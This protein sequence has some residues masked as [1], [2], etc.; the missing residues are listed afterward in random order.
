MKKFLLSSL[1][2]L[3]YFG[4]SANI[5]Y[6]AY[7][8]TGSNDGTSWA[9]AYTHPSDAFSAAG[10]AGTD[11]I[12]VKAGTYYP[13]RRTN[14]QTQA[15]KSREFTF[16]INKPLKVFGG[17]AGTE[18]LPDDR[19]LDV[20]TTV[21]S[22]DIGTSG[23]AS[24][25][26]YH[27]VTI[28]NT[29]NVTFDGFSI[30]K[31]MADG[32]G[33]DTNGAG[34]WVSSISTLELANLTF[35]DNHAE[36]DGGGMAVRNLSYCTL[37]GATFCSNS[38][39]FGGGID[40]R[41]ISACYLYNVKLTNNSAEGSGGAVHGNNLSY[42]IFANTLFCNNEAE[43]GGGLAGWQFSAT[44]LVNTTFYNNSADD[45]SS[46]YTTQHST[47]NLYNSILWG[48]GDGGACA[49][50]SSSN[51][52]SINAYNSIIEGSGGS[53]G[54]WAS[55]ASDMGGNLDQDPQFIDPDGAD[56]SFCTSDDNFYLSPTSP[57]ID[58]GTTLGLPAVPAEDINGNNRVQGT[59]PDIGAFEGSGGSST[60]PVEWLSFEAQWINNGTEGVMLTWATAQ[61]I[62]NQGFTLE[63]RL[64][65]DMGWESIGNVDGVGQ[66]DEVTHYEFTDESASDI[67]SDRLEYR[68][69]Q[70]DLDGAYSYSTVQRLSMDRALGNRI[71]LYP[72]PASG[73]V[74]IATDL[75]EGLRV[76]SIE[77]LDLQGKM[78]FS[79]TTAESL[80]DTYT[81]NIE[82]LLPGTYL[83][84]LNHSAG[85][86]GQLLTVQP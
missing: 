26:V 76:K 11:S 28:N 64:S 40:L 32:S 85:Q 15:H 37:T 35:S 65:E 8:A 22:G 77:V 75:P 80:T 67:W 79:Q 57:A 74:N 62:N 43:E 7:D 68:I 33:N 36:G 2:L 51:Y 55:S 72:N 19:N 45:G 54:S 70:T 4:L 69:K 27:V 30:M 63:R 60:F 56:N 34:L 14:G 49:P 84:R 13:D 12:F 66:S 42:M 18:S 17:F 6:V 29:T 47:L 44:D 10:W 48:C 1:F 83:L 24:D 53:G 78:M 81:L 59:Q 16:Y 82:A 25:N 61:E 3:L 9:N 23:D 58:N 50:L 20:Y 41:S 39:E 86:V 21:L 38:A 73:R 46:I 5:I 71:M 31:G 52:S